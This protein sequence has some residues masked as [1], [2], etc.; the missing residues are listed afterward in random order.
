MRKLSQLAAGLAVSYAALRGG[1]QSQAMAGLVSLAQNGLA[2]KD[3]DQKVRKKARSIG[4]RTA[5]KWVKE[6]Q[7]RRKRQ[8]GGAA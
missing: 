1:D 2:L 5:L 4:A 3:F 6:Q 7:E 8:P